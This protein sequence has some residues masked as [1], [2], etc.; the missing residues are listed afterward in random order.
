MM[1]LDHLT[2]A[3]SRIREIEA[4]LEKLNGS[5]GGDFGAMLA[6]CLTQSPPEVTTEIGKLGHWDT[7]P[8]FPISQF[9]NFPT[10][11]SARPALIKGLSTDSISTIS[12]PPGPVP[13]E[14]YDLIRQAAARYGLDEN[15]VLAVARA[16]SGFRPEAVSR[17]GALGVMQLMP[18]TARSLGVTDPLDPAQNIDGGAR[19]L[20]QMLDRFGGDVE[21][22][23]AGYNA[24]PGAVKRYDGVPPYRETQQYVQRVLDYQRQFAAAGIETEPKDGRRPSE[25]GE[26]SGPGLGPDGPGLGENSGLGGWG[27]E[28]QNPITPGAVNPITP[29]AANPSNPI[30][31]E[32]RVPT[33]RV[34]PSPSPASPSPGSESGRVGEWESG[35][36]ESLEPASPAI[37]AAEDHAAGNV[38][39]LSEFATAVW[40]TAQMMLS[41]RE[42]E[43]TA[44]L[45][46]RQQEELTVR[47]IHRDDAIQVFVQVNDE[48]L[49]RVLETGAPLLAEALAAH[50][51]SLGEFQVGSQE[52]DPQSAGQ[53]PTAEGWRLP[54]PN[55][56]GGR[57][58]PLSAPVD[59]VEPLIEEGTWTAWA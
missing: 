47:V 50:H 24:G 36:V 53:S 29:G 10:T 42:Q 20:R 25:R 15:L 51:L 35:S 34:R 38:T 3:L 58:A 17:A 7:G 52:A 33:S 23:L 6:H 4:R 54:A 27:G 39:D 45:T 49:R 37:G 56:T 5:S 1:N 21:Q 41:Q 11:W 57:V 55:T 30:T 9:P 32:P 46:W 40:H 16:E 48:T 14:I 18:G 12:R 44:H 13:A 43:F 19:Y 8:N 59:P 28:P 31:P 22:A 26:A 2:H